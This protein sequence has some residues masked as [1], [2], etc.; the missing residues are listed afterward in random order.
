MEI[1]K[2]IIRPTLVDFKEVLP[3]WEAA[4]NTGMIT[5]NKYTRKF[6]EAIEQRQKVKQAIAMNSCTS[7]LILALKVLGLTGEVIVPAFTFA[8]TAQGGVS[9]LA[10]VR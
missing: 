4:W 6:E 9:C 2:P 8:A 3:L 7:G 1:R 5:T 10:K